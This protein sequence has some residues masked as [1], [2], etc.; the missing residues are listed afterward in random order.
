[1]QH[2]QFFELLWNSRLSGR[3]VAI[4][5]HDDDDAMMM[6]MMMMIQTK[7]DKSTKR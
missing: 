1:M 3:L 7:I 4:S 2:R 6:M 5:P